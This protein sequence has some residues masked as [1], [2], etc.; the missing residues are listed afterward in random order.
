MDI[1]Q[2][3]L[4]MINNNKENFTTPL[5]NHDGYATGYPEGYNDALV[6]LLNQ[7]GIEHNEEIMN[8]WWNQDVIGIFLVNN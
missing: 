4:D 3:I 7:L 6:D 2:I 1:K 8:N 5:Y